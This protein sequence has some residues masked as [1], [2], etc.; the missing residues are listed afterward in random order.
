MIIKFQN[1]FYSGRS[2]F[3]CVHT[4]HETTLGVVQF[5]SFRWSNSEQTGAG[6][7][8]FTLQMRSN[9]FDPKQGWVTAGSTGRY[10]A[11]W[12]IYW[13]GYPYGPSYANLFVGRLEQ[14]LLQTER[15]SLL[16]TICI[17]H[18]QRGILN[19]AFNTL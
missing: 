2:Q 10:H 5:N 9:Q 16:T 11:P 14:E 17:H 7:F 19:S 1:C 8:A 18:A 3:V 12:S 6:W 13:H 4:R 15:S